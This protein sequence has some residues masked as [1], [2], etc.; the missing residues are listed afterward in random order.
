MLLQNF[1]LAFNGGTGGLGNA[2]VIQNLELVI[3]ILIAS[4]S[5]TIMPIAGAY[6]GEGNRC[7]THM[8]RRFSLVFGYLILIPIFVVLIIFPNSFILIFV[9]DNEYMLN[10]LPSAV[11]ISMVAFLFSMFSQIQQSYYASIGKEKVYM[12]AGIIQTVCQILSLIVLPVITPQN[13]TW[14]ALLVG[15]LAS[16]IYIVVF[17][18]G[19]EG[20]FRFIRGNV[21]YMTGDRYDLTALIDRIKA[22]TKMILSKEEVDTLNRELLVPL[23]ESFP[24]DTKTLGSFTILDIPDCAKTAIFHFDSNKKLKSDRSI[25][26]ITDEFCMMRRKK[27]RLS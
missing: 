27:I 8:V 17:N 11:R 1:I 14:Y 25:E 19:F 5:G 9:D 13:A 24:K 21:L 22:E 2:A 20:V 12:I 10:T 23:Y 15:T 16:S 3:T 7:G 18:R 4:I 26:V 6:N